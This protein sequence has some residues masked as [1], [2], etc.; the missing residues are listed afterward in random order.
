[1]KGEAAPA[2]ESFTRYLQSYPG[3]RFQPECTLLPLRHRQRAER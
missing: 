1:M 3:R 2:K